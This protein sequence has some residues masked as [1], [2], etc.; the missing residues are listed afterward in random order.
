[1]FVCTLCPLSETVKIAFYKNEHEY[2]KWKWMKMGKNVFAKM[3]IRIFTFTILQF[4]VIK[5]VC[6]LAK[7]DESKQVIQHQNQNKNATPNEMGVNEYGW[8][9]SMSFSLNVDVDVDC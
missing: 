3:N 7:G 8:C 1:M 5:I 4:A 6:D 2:S 9:R